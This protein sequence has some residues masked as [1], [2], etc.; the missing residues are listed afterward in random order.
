MRLD[1]FLADCALGSRR[2]LKEAIRKRS[3]TVNGVPV[4]DPSFSVSEEDDVLFCG[5]PAVY[6]PFIYLMMNKPAG[7]LSATEDRSKPTVLDLLPDSYRHYALFPVGRLDIDT[8]GLLLLTNDGALA[9]KATA[10]KFHV[11]KTYYTET[12]LPIG[13]D[14][15]AR[16]SEGVRIA[17]G[18]VTAPARLRIL[19]DKS[20]E[21]TITEGKFH[22]VKQM[23]ESVGNRVTYL[24][25][26][27]FGA[28]TLDPALKPGKFR[29]LLPEER[30]F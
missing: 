13:S 26:I 25:R 1:K 24:K 27:S 17:G 19:S 23:F 12:A 4:S 29:P 7:V 8:E 6:T 20:A 3:V 18:Y 9:H 16:F 21:L 14:T 11:D 30:V 5:K 22:Q 10:P 2:E 28:L 15:A